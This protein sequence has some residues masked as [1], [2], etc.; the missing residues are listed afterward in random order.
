MSAP[1]PQ[2]PAIKAPPVHTTSILPAASVVL[3][4]VVM[5]VI[6]AFLNVFDASTTTAT[7]LP[8]IV[9]GLPQAATTNVFDS[10]KD[11]GILPGDVA[12]A[13]VVPATTTLVR[14][15][16]TG[17]GG[18]ANYDRQVDLSVVA[19]RAPLLGFYRSHLEALGWRLISRGTST[20][21]GAQ[22]L[23]LKAGSDG[24][25]WE[26]GVVAQRTAGAVTAFSYRLIQESDIS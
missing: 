24:W 17:G 15:V 20:G 11:P 8:V 26:A 3:V 7:T 1:A 4:A 18:V 12:A 10:F 21:G 9:G 25:Y 22:L 23:F 16:T 14:G 6:F 2:S 19:Q 5:L 13:L